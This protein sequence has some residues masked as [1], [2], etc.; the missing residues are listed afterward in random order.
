MSPSD[1]MK[2]LHADPAFSA[3]R[4]QRGRDRFKAN[5]AEL[6]RK[7]N[8]KRR[9]VDVPESLEGAWQRCKAKKMTNQEA[10]RFLGLKF[11]GPEEG[12]K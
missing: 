11:K 1:R 8:A 4:D 5:H 12:S 7:S 10:A 2:G 9:G 6:Q 3:A